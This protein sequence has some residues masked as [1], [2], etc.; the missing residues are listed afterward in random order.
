MTARFGTTPGTTHT[1]PGTTLPGGHR[2]QLAPDHRLRDRHVMAL[3]GWFGSARGWG[4]L[5]EYLD[6]S[7]FTYV[8]P[9]LRGYGSRTGR[10]RRVH[11]GEAAADALALADELGWDRFA[12]VGHSMSGKAVQH[13]V[14]AGARPG[15]PAGGAQARCPPPACPSTTTAG[16]CSPVP[17]TAPENRAAIITMTTGGRLS[18]TFIDHVVQHSL[19]NSTV[20]A[21]GAYLESW[22]REDFSEPRAGEPGPGQGHRRGARP[23]AVGAGDGA[24]LSGAAARTRNWRCSRT[25]GTTRCSR[26]RWRWPRAME[27]FLGRE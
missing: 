14:L 4:S 22:A 18:P 26:R 16:R 19:D 12:M 3:H 2:G 13:A 23:R 6:G 27:E 9:D 21:F 17:P 1:R 20:P 8:F 24:D 10:D 25:P 11:H 5:P 7:A 15:H